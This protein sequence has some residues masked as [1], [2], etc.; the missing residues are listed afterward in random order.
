MIALWLI[1][2]FHFKQRGTPYW[3]KIHNKCVVQ[4]WNRNLREETDGTKNVTLTVNALQWWHSVQD[5]QKKQNKQKTNKTA[6]TVCIPSVMAC[7][8]GLRAVRWSGTQP[9]PPPACLNS[10]LVCEGASWSLRLRI[11]EV[12]SYS[13]QRWVRLVRY[14]SS[15][16]T[17]FDSDAPFFF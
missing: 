2:G 6:P 11:A 7:K 8:D 1:K 4:R 12:A 15:G 9:G 17:V 5:C 3:D 13:V 10:L 16:G 14:S